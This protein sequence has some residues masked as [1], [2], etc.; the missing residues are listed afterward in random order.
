MGKK[1]LR[2]I[3]AQEDKD[4]KGQEKQFLFFCS[5]FW[6]VIFGVLQVF[7]GTPLSSVVLHH[8]ET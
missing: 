2:H 6:S 5:R 1:V 3:R 7:P 4:I 8:P